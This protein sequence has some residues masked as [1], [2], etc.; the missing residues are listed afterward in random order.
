MN[1]LHLLGSPSILYSII[2]VL[3]SSTGGL[4]IKSCSTSTELTTLQTK[5][6]QLQDEN[7]RLLT[8]QAVIQNELTKQS[9]QIEL[10]NNLAGRYH[11]EL[12]AKYTTPTPPPQP[13][14]FDFT[15]ANSLLYKQGTKP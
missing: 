11:K 7:V 12:E 10:Y 9:K 5:Y 4:V 6:N 15:F 13:C 3:F 1:L 14:N 8:N 2:A